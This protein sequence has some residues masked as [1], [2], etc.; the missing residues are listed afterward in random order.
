MN[1]FENVVLD[2]FVCDKII[3]S[4]QKKINLKNKKYSNDDGWADYFHYILAH[5]FD[6]LCVL[7]TLE[8]IF[9]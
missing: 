9:T 1:I 2:H 4:V 5:L 3:D 6:L 7:L 8:I